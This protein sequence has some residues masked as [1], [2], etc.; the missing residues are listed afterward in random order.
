MSHERLKK[1]NELWSCNPWDLQAHLRRAGELT[2]G[3]A[4]HLVYV[5]VI[6]SF[7]VTAYWP[8]ISIIAFTWAE[9]LKDVLTW[10]QAITADG[11]T[12]EVGAD[13]Y[14]RVK[15]AILSVANVQDLNHATRV[16]CQTSLQRHISK[17]NLADVTT[18]NVVLTDA[19]LV[20][21]MFELR[22]RFFELINQLVFRNFSGLTFVRL[23]FL[24]CVVF[25]SDWQTLS[26][27]LVEWS[28]LKEYMRSTILSWPNKASLK[29]SF[30]RTYLHTYTYI[31]LSVHPQNVFFDF[32]EIR[33]VGRGR[34]V[35]H[36]AM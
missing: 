14:F 5:D 8:Q 33:H 29:C 32:N 4:T 18:D 21:I 25:H 2:L 19:L 34:W 35:M 1:I 23:K 31:H 3:F 28:F 9:E 26:I 20:R 11:A 10:M 12:I 17:Q 30:I 22:L 36:G 27:L 24:C 6:W 13:V 7:L 15:D 16:L